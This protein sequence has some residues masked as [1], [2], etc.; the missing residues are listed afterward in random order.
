MAASMRRNEIDFRASFCHRGAK[1]EAKSHQEL[2]LNLLNN[3][4][5]DLYAESVVF[6]LVDAITG[7]VT[8]GNLY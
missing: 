7:I 2:I 4:D 5:C 3:T 6:S 8:R 1:G